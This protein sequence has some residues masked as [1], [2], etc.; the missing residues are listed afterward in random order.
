MYPET[1]NATYE[2]IAN[3]ILRLMLWMLAGA[4]V[5]LC[6]AVVFLYRER[7]TLQREMI[8]ANFDAIQALNNVADAIEAVRTDIAQSKPPSH[9]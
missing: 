2:T 7:Q 6:G 4:V 8:T 1:V 9:E 3:P 5:A